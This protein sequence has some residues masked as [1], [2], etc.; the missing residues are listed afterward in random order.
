MDYVDLVECVFRSSDGAFIPKDPNN[1][2]YQSYLLW[3]DQPQ[4]ATDSATE[5]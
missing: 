5:S 2:D 4:E 1:M 3:L